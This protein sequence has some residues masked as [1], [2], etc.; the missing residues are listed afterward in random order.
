MSPAFAA[1]IAATS[2]SAPAPIAGGFGTPF[3]GTPGATAGALPPIPPA[4]PASSAPVDDPNTLADESEASADTQAP[5]DPN[6]RSQLFGSSEAS[7]LGEEGDTGISPPPPGQGA[8]AL[9]GGGVNFDFGSDPFAAASSPLPSAAPAPPPAELF[10]REPAKPAAPP[11]SPASAP[12]IDI[13]GPP[14]GAAARAQKK[15][16][17]KPAPKLTT[18]RMLVPQEP[19][20]AFRLLLALFFAGAAVSAFASLTEGTLDPRRIDRGRLSLLIGPPP[21]AENLAGLAITARRG[22]YVTTPPGKPRVYMAQGVAINAGDAPKGFIEVRGRMLAD[23]GGVLAETTAPCGNSFRDDQLLGFRSGDELKR[24]YL[25]AGD[26][27]SNA[28]L[29]PGSAVACT[30]VFFEA[31]APE[32][33]A[34]F[35]LEIVAAQP[36][37]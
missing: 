13:A 9:T 22:G 18:A 20:R 19:V 8:P 34:R 37:S 12:S 2:T 32:K 3:V 11:P 4:M 16:A 1:G 5:F 28:K 35:E 21:V 25:P 15:P 23:D 30:V 31:P 26:G 24:S 6:M 33:T 27:S 29:A 17:K 36:V 7:A 14:A 10:A